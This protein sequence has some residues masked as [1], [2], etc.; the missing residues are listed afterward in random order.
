MARP[1]HSAAT[2]E[3]LRQTLL[4]AALALYLEEG[5]AQVTLRQIAARVGMSHTMGYRYFANK[6]ALIAEMRRSCLRELRDTITP[7]LPDSAP[8][9]ERVRTALMQLLRYGYENPAQYRLIFSDSQADLAMHPDLLEERSALFNFSKELVQRA[10][11]ERSLQGDALLITHGLW[12]L[13]H[14]MLALHSANQLV[15]GL[16]L[17]QMAAPL[18]D[19]MLH[20]GCDR[21]ITLSHS[22]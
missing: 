3:Q 12:S 2:T 11:D 22:S 21:P 7:A 5:M 9:L 18:I 14:G 1:N 15:N 8:A 10:I 13:L 19:S 4:R 6:D 17:M 16:S 20:A